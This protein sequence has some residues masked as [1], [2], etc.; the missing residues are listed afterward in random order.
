MTF[1]LFLTDF[2]NRRNFSNYF[3]KFCF[4]NVYAKTDPFRNKEI[5][6]LNGGELK[7]AT[8]IEGLT[9][10]I[11]IIIIIIIVSFFLQQLGFVGKF[12]DCS[13]WLIFC[14]LDP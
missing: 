2:F 10:I 4:K 8:Y 13:L 5:Y 9:T 7:P 6:L 1:S 14:A 11:I 3:S 12:I